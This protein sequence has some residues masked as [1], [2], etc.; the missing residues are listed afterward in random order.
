MAEAGLM[1]AENV[2][3][4]KSM[5]SQELIDEVNQKYDGVI[6]DNFNKAANEFGAISSNQIKSADPV[7]YVYPAQRL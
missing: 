2:G 6:P 4:I 1:E 7:T 3:A 5:I